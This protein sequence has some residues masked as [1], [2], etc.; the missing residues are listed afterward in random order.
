[1]RLT[2]TTVTVDRSALLEQFAIANPELAEAHSLTEA[3]EAGR[4]AAVAQWWPRLDVAGAYLLF[5]SPT[6]DVQGEWNVGFRLSYPLFTGGARSRA[7]S[8]ASARAELAREQYRLT[9]LQGEEA[10]DRAL[11]AVREWRAQVDAVGT[12]VEHLT[13]VAR[14]ERLALQE[15]AGTQTDYLSAE[16]ELRRASASLVRA[17]HAEIAARVELASITGTL[18]PR[19]ISDMLENAP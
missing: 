10:V 2:D 12:A 3:A 15:G 5:S 1:M 19:W 17:R 11:G 18:S 14:I 16:A 6:F 13:E 4:R 7:V 8:S 9:R